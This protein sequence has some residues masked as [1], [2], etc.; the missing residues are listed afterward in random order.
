MPLTLSRHA[1]MVH[2]FQQ[3]EDPTSGRRRCGVGDVV[4]SCLLVLCS[5]LAQSA[6]RS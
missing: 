2:A 1:D 4:R 3:L 5:L 6:L